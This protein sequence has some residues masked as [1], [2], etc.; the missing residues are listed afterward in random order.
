MGTR[1]LAAPHRQSLS[2]F[3]YE[4]PHRHRLPDDWR[5]YWKCED[6]LKFEEE[7]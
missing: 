3:P 1:I 2:D 7:S 4:K 5:A 6:V